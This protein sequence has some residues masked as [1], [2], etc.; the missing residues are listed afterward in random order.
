VRLVAS[1][2]V[3]LRDRVKAGRFREDLYYRLNVVPIHVPSLRERREDIPL[4][5]REFLHKHDTNENITLDP[6]LVEMLMNHT[7]PGN[8]R[9]LENLIAR[10]VILRQGDA[11]TPRDLPDDFGKFDPREEV[12]H[13][14]GRS[15]ETLE[16]VEKNMILDAL[17]KTGWNKT[18]AAKRLDI[19][20]HVLIYRLKKFGIEDPES[21]RG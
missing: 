17:G 2:N 16:E 9:E 10:M 13:T 12:G 3:D 5:A 11:L 8:V 19:A 4:L 15:R 7:W 21:T 18:K 20:R 6:S 14:N 1:T